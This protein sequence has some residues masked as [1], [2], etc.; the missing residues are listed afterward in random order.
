SLVTLKFIIMCKMGVQV[1]N[2]DA[3]HK[4]HLDC[5]TALVSKLNPW[6]VICFDDVWFKDFEWQGKGKNAIPFLIKN[7]FTVVQTG[8][9]AAILVRS[10]EN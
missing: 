8:N 5:T 6:G 2:D 7:S 3:C 10:D 4:M 1:I 9:N